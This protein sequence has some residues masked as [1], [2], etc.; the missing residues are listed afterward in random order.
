M[1]ID[2]VFITECIADRHTALFSVHLCQS[3]A[4]QKIAGCKA[5]QFAH[6]KCHREISAR[7]FSQGVLN[8]ITSTHICLID[9]L[10]A[11]K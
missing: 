3:V 2:V 11:G 1:Y 4:T 8:Y 10:S 7:H 5:V 6:T 9:G